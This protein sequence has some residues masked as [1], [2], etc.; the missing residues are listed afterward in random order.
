MSKISIP[1]LF[2]IYLFFA[3]CQN[4]PVYPEKPSISFGSV[5]FRDE[6]PTDFIYL[7]LNFKDGDGD[8]GL[9]STDILNSPFTEL[10]DSSGIQIRNP[11]R[12]NIFPVLYRKEGNEYLAVPGG[13]FDGIFP[14]LRSTEEKGPI[15]GSILYK[16]P[17][18]NFFGE[19]SS[20]A[21]IKV[22]IQDRAL[23]KSN[24]IETPPFPVI[25]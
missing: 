21:K 13:G 20:I 1:V 16:L 17:S 11:N 12:F 2:L 4:I 19:D 7:T 24:V 14:R 3:G 6:S 5:F 22:F 18:I 23:N 15:E 10:I 25:Y 9:S 8:L